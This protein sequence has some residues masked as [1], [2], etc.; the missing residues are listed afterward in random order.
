MPKDFT[1]K[2]FGR[3]LRG[4]VPE[5]VD[6]YISY[7][8][9]EYAKIE[10]AKNDSDRKLG[11]ALVK[12]DE[13]TKKLSS[14][15]TDE[16]KA[17]AESI[18]SE[19]KK[20]ADSLA[21]QAKKEA[22]S[23]AAQAKKEADSLVNNAKKEAA[24]I[25]E[26]AKKN[27]DIE[28]KR[29]VDEM[30][31]NTEENLADSRA[32]ADRLK[33]KAMQMRKDTLAMYDEVCSFRDSLFEIYSSHIDSIEHMADRADKFVENIDS[34]TDSDILAEN[35]AT[36]PAEQEEYSGEIQIDWKNHTAVVCTD[37][38]DEEYGEDSL[39]YDEEGEYLDG[40]YEY[41]VYDYDE[42]DEADDTVFDD[43]ESEDF[44]VSA[45]DA[46]YKDVDLFYSSSIK[47][48]SLS[49][50]GEFDIVFDAAKTNSDIETIRRQET[51]AS[52][53]PV[54]QKKRKLF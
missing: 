34:L 10:R 31:K 15:M 28:S 54:K 29:I 8:N 13:L 11:I 23:L 37:A 44:D 20:E 3:I 12:L 4:Y 42:Y 26:S 51:V 40:T 14:S 45:D 35:A 32:E 43:H 53:E 6:E 7:L 52:S 47:L 21:A 9:D 17:Q 5:E 22:D 36:V 18:L 24:S 19:A 39:E 16:A 30:V 41:G 49:S 50:E 27:A 46:E 33:K 48:E 1:N 25:L 38:S 2:T